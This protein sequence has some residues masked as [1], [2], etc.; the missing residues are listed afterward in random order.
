ME[1]GEGRHGVGIRAWDEEVL[2][3]EVE[4]FLRKMSV[5]PPISTS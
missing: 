4:Y 2:G 3:E 1:L 5:L